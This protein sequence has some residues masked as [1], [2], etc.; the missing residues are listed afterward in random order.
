MTLVLP[1]SGAETVQRERERDGE[2]FRCEYRRARTFEK[3]G[4]DSERRA[5]LCT[6]TVHTHTNSL[7]TFT[8]KTEAD[9]TGTAGKGAHLWIQ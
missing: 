1:V 2:H 7:S 4:T 3:D 6:G 5:V 9:G 8:R